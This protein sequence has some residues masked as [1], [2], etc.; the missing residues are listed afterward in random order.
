METQVASIVVTVWSFEGIFLQR[1]L[2]GKS[3][4]NDIMAHVPRS[5]ILFLLCHCNTDWL[6]IVL[7]ID[8]LFCLFGSVFVVV[9]YI[10]SFGSS[11][12]P[13]DANRIVENMTARI[14]CRIFIGKVQ[15]IG[16][17]N[18]PPVGIKPAPVYVAN[19]ASQI[20]TGVVYFLDRRFKWIAKSSVLYLPGVGQIMYLS[21]HV[22]IDRNKRKNAKSVSTLFDK[23]NASVQ[24]G[25]PMFFFPQG[26]RQI[27]E[28]LPGKDG[29][30]IVAQTNKSPLVPVSIDIPPTVWKSLYPLNLLWNGD[31][32]IIKLTIHP[33][34]Q[35][36]GK[37][38]R[39]TLNQQ[40]MNQI[41]SVLPKYESIKDR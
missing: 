13:K 24:S 20:D 9:K 19:H 15:V 38:D 22:F 14:C 11:D 16:W 7:T 23:S 2:D 41:Y 12:I 1:I 29:A 40:C 10:F 17:D 5:V 8:K 26:T 25:L 33:V 30:F 27:A 4:N 35:V 3:M 18:L 37:E 34:V 36:S 21:Q 39:E 28:R 6:C 31:T 32:P